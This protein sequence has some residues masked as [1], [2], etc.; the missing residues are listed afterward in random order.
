MDNDVREGEDG[1]LRSANA[2]LSSEEAGDL[3]YT[4]EQCIPSSLVEK[5]L[6]LILR[7]TIVSECVKRNAG[8]AKS[9]LIIHYL[10]NVVPQSFF[11]LV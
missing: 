5:W 9:V 3:D 2:S 10:F 8:C 4:G 7:K 1:G 11:R 6:F